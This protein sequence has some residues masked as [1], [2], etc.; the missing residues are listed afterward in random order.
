MDAMVFVID[1]EPADR[2]QALAW[3]AEVGVKAMA[4]PKVG[5]MFHHVNDT[6]PFVVIL[7]MQMN[8]N[9]LDSHQMLIRHGYG[10]AP[11]IFLTSQQDIDIASKCYQ[12]GAYGYMSKAQGNRE[13][14]QQTVLRAMRDAPKRL[15]EKMRVQAKSSLYLLT[16]AE[17]EVFELCGNARISPSIVAKAF[18]VQTAT[19][20]TM[21]TSIQKK[22]QARSWAQVQA[23]HLGESILPGLTP[24]ER[25]RQSR[26][27]RNKP[28]DE[29]ELPDV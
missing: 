23:E 16:P 14:L 17:L 7:D 3:L 8:P 18:G 15:D 11:V 4:L 5:Y 6:Q 20:A 22:L 10:W 12:A 27:A 13:Q 29:G 25:V 21:R 28:F 2:E 24:I 9:G 1:D 26:I 19:L